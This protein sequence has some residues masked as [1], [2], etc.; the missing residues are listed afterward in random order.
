MR[1]GQ[2]MLRNYK[3][4]SWFYSSFIIQHSSIFFHPSSLIHRFIWRSIPK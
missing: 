3:R 1:S 4:F 2:Y